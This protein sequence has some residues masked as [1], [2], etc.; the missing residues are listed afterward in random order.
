MTFSRSH[1]FAEDSNFTVHLQSGIFQGLILGRILSPSQ[2][3]NEQKL[4]KMVYIILI[5]LVLHFGEHFMKIRTKIPKLQIYVFIHIFMQFFMSFYGGQLKQQTCYSFTLPISY[6]FLK[7]WSSSFRLHQVFQI[8]MVQMFFFPNSKGPWPR[9]QKGRKIPV[10]NTPHYNSDLDI[11][12]SCCGFHFFN[13][14]I[15]Q[16][17][18]NSL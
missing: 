9:L 15:L 7:C 8:L 3:K 16:R 4:P 11:T 5:F 18:Y 12:W 2:F 1:G 6:M 13:D 10:Y 14:G 17:K